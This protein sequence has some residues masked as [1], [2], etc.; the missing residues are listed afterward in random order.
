MIPC[1]GDSRTELQE[2]SMEFSCNEALKF[3]ICPVGDLAG[4]S[5]V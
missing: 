3:N 2:L 1:H 5:C 4:N